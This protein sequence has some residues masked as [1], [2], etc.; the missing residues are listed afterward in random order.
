MKPTITIALML[1]VAH[2]AAG[3]TS[4]SLKSQSKDV[5]FSNT[6]STRPFKLGAEL[7]AT[8]TTGEMFFLTT[9]SNSQNI[10]SC[11]NGDWVG[12]GTQLD[13]IQDG[14]VVRTT[15]GALLARSLEP[16]LGVV[17]QNGSGAT[18][19]PVIELDDAVAVLYS[20]SASNPVGSCSP[21][22]LHYRTDQKVLWF[23]GAENQWQQIP[24]TSAGTVS[25]ALDSSQ[26]HE[27]DEFVG[28]T[29]RL[30]ASFTSWSS[31]C[32]SPTSIPD[33]GTAL[34]PWSVTFG[35]TGTT[36]GHGRTIAWVGFH[37]PT[38]TAGWAVEFIFKLDS[39]TDN[40]FRI[41][42]ANQTA[43]VT[44]TNFIGVRAD[45][46]S[47][48][49]N[50]STPQLSLTSC[51]GSLPS[52]CASLNLGVPV[53]TQYHR[54]LLYSDTAQVISAV[55][56][57]DPPRT[58]CASSTCTL[59]ATGTYPAPTQILPIHRGAG[60]HRNVFFLPG[61]TVVHAPAESI[62]RGLGVLHFNAELPD[63]NVAPVRAGPKNEIIRASSRECKLRTGRASH[64]P[65]PLRG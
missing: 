6:S 53:D 43:S 49:D 41:G 35:C 16:G 19:N 17:V 55:W 3:Q 4:I 15:S 1:L 9:A 48:W 23:C 33:T 25:P 52:S 39:A 62:G 59:D 37:E 22:R 29:T 45:S 46:D 26:V 61:R 24:S 14:L 50:A 64:Q 51:N 58:I 8:C 30:S 65:V 60:R 57:D 56:D 27:V 32:T 20:T 54:L 2:V 38:N 63:L 7:P 40:R 36:T 12:V 47:A 34:N 42:I 5:D 10:H 44:P 28:G 18:G 13:T 31:G 21:G 11:V